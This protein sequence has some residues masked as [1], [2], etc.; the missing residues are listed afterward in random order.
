MKT[1]PCQEHINFICNLYNDTYDDREE[2]SRPGG[3]SWE[4]GVKARHKSLAAYKRELEVQ[5]IKLSTSKILRI[6]ITGGCPCG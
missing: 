1:N 2:D 3:E 5:G 6:L 4:P